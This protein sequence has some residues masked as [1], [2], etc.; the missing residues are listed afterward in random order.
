ML[1]GKDSQQKARTKQQEFAKLDFRGTHSHK[2]LEIEITDMKE[3]EGGVQIMARARRGAH[4]VGFGE[5]GSVD[6][7]KF[8]IINP[9]ILVQDPN[10]DIQKVVSTDETHTKTVFYREDPLQATIETLEHTISVCG[11]EGSTKIQPGK[12]GR[13]TATIYPD[14]DPES[15]SCDGNVSDVV[16]GGNWS[17][18]HNDSN[19]NG[20]DDSGTGLHVRSQNN[21]GQANINRMFLLFDTS[22][23]GSRATISSATISLYGTGSAFTGGSENIRCVTTNPSSNTGLQASDYSTCGTTA[24]SSSE[25]ALNGVSTTGYNDWPL[26][27]TGL[28]NISLTGISKFGMRMTND[29]NNSNPAGGTKGATFYSAD[30]SGTS[31]DPKIVITYT[32]PVTSSLTHTSDTDKKGAGTLT[33]GSDAYL[34]GTTTVT[35][36][37]DTDL[38]GNKT[39]LH[40][41]DGDLKGARAV[42]H[43]ID[44]DLKGSPAVSSSSDSL[45]RG[46]FVITHAVD[47]LLKATTV[48]SHA[49]D[50]YLHFIVIVSHTSDTHLKANRSLPHT[51]DALLRTSFTRAHATD[52]LLLAERTPQHASDALLRSTSTASHGTDSLLLAIEKVE[53]QTDALLRAAYGRDHTTDALLRASMLVSQQADSLL[54]A[55][56][57]RSQP[58][59]SAAARRTEPATYIRL[60]SPSSHCQNSCYRCA[61]ARKRPAF[62][63]GG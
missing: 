33:H 11:I 10:G 23:L 60:T 28:S 34:K 44:A 3:I 9:P 8:I 62:P 25:V 29:A 51:S 59:R 27:S 5:D 56:F 43:T 12:I 32:A 2:G 45:L 7:E 30:Q 53:Q 20:V 54:Q 18:L 31:N 40:T 22:I 16:N 14:A 37:T 57:A 38:K 52:T 36:T 4:Q 21:G 35:N 63:H 47:T 15:T 41:S 46:M 1:A 42:A 13:T 17:T 39:V 6:I 48:Q 49:T 61:L 58:N 19:G 50:A 26:N 24:Q 55:A